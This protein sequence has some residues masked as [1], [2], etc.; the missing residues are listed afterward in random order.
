MMMMGW[1]IIID[2]KEVPGIWNSASHPT[3]GFKFCWGGK[4]LIYIFHR[5]FRLS[6]QTTT[7]QNYF[8][9]A[10]NSSEGL[11]SLRIY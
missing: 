1:V 4:G 11:G 7:S 9:A 8:V 10:T 2:V 3:H 6:T 5:E